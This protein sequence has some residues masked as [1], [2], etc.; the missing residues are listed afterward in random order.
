[1][2]LRHQQLRRRAAESFVL[3]L[4]VLALVGGALGYLWWSKENNE[5]AARQF[6]EDAAERIL[7]QQDEHFLDVRLSPEAQVTYPP[8]WRSRLFGHLREL[9]SPE[10]NFELTGNTAFTSFFFEPKG[11]FRLKAHYQSN[12]APA[13][14]SLGVSHPQALWQIDYINLIWTPL[15]PAPAPAPAQPNE[16]LPPSP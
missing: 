13:T 1:M 6:A 11:M 14:L 5:K 12:P 4:I 15:R 10:K 2:R 7:R 8:S 3:I 16:Q 9:G